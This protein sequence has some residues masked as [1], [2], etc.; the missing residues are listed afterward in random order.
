MTSKHKCIKHPHDRAL[1]AF[2]LQVLDVMHRHAEWN[3]DTTK[4][5]AYKAH[6]LG[7]AHA[8]PPDLPSNFNVIPRAEF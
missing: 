2:G 6:N 3:S 4:E 5:I 1:I 8:S 7:L